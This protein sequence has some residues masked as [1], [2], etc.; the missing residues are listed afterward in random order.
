MSGNQYDA[1]ITTFI[2]APILNKT[3]ATLS[4]SN[5]GAGGG[6]TLGTDD[7]FPQ[8]TDEVVQRQPFYDRRGASND[9]SQ[10]LKK[11]DQA[12][13]GTLTL[14]NNFADGLV[15][16]S[17]K[18][19]SN[20]FP[21]DPTNSSVISNDLAFRL[22]G[23][24]VDASDVVVNSGTFDVPFHGWNVPHEVNFFSPLSMALLRGLGQDGVKATGIS[25]EMLVA[26]NPAFS[27]I[28][29]DTGF[30]SKRCLVWATLDIR[31]TF[32]TDDMV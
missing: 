13:L 9:L 2:T 28:T 31:H 27:T 23:F 32:G 20:P 12:F 3:W 5:A 4:N 18:T 6:V 7:W 30:Q 16:V 11:N 17:D 26:N 15:D 1:I 21:T 24:Y 10:Y 14:W 29:I 22:A 19:V 8:K 25:I